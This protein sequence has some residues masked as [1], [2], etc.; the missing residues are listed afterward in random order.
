MYL[1]NAVL[2]M[3]PE[4]CELSSD[5]NVCAWLSAIA[6]SE[7]QLIVSRDMCETLT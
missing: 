7:P 3:F 4:R 5:K 6:I 2:Q 1:Q